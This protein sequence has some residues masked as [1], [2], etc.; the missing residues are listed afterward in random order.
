MEKIIVDKTSCPVCTRPTI[1]AKAISETGDPKDAGLWYFCLC[2]VIF[3]SKT[4]SVAPKDKTYIKQYNE[5]KEY[6]LVSKESSRVYG[7]IIEELTMGRK[8]LDVGFCTE[9]NINHFKERGWVTFGI[10]NN[11]DIKETDRIINDDFEKTERLYKSTY[12]LVFM[13]HVLEKFR[14]PLSALFKAR[15]ILQSNGVLYVST[16]DNDF[17][18]SEPPAEWTHWNKKE[19]NILWNKRSL[20]RELERIGF[21]IVMV[22]R[23][24]HSRW[25]F[26]HDLHIIAQKVYL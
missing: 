18:Y 20:T 13:G 25:G 10:D 9:H 7:P 3:N 8:M 15:E 22:R 19:N 11:K 14:D 23:N 1:R 2:G 4:P 21:N 16:P 24:Y 26:Y 5:F 17:L 6:E 12:D